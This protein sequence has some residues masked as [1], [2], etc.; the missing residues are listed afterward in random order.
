MAAVTA[1]T[2]RSAPP[3][4]R[5]GLLR[6]NS[7]TSSNSRNASAFTGSIASSSSST[8]SNVHCRRHSARTVFALILSS[9]RSLE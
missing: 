2:Q 6:R 1:R 7:V 9:S 8:R 3:R 5:H 4:L